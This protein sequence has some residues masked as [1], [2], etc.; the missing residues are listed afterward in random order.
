MPNG[1]LRSTLIQDVRPFHQVKFSPDGTLLAATIGRFAG[2]WETSSGRQKL[3]PGDHPGGIGDLGFVDDENLAVAGVDA[4]G[5]GQVQLWNLVVAPHQIT[6]ESAS[7][8][9]PDVC[10]FGPD[11]QTFAVSRSGSIDVRDTQ[12]GKHVGGTKGTERTFPTSFAY[13]QSGNALIVVGI[14]SS[15]LPSEP[16]A[17]HGVATCGSGTSGRPSKCQSLRISRAPFNA[18]PS[19]LTGD[20]LPRTALSASICETTQGK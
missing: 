17:D 6:L 4:E 7:L 14:S 2:V 9:P 12:S 20:S 1:E 11:G 5:N 19:V 18:L 3:F 13:T 15:H 10:A 8:A 16:S